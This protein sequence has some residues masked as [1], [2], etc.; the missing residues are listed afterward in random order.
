[1]YLI[2]LISSI[3]GFVLTT[4]LLFKKPPI[5]KATFFLGCFYLILSIYALQTYMIEAGHLNRF[6]WFFLWPLALYHLIMV[7]MYFYFEA[8][9]EDRFYWKKRYLLLFVP[10]LLGIMDLIAVYTT[11][12]MADQILHE[13]IA[14]TGNRLKTRYWLL[15]LNEHYLIRHIW[16]CA[17]LLVLLPK[18][19][20]FLK[21]GASNKS[22]IILNKWLV[23]FW[24]IL[25]MLSLMTILQGMEKWMDISV[26]GYFFGVG[27]G[28]IIVAII[29]YLCVLAIG[30]TPIYFPSILYGYPRPKKIPSTVNTKNKIT[31]KSPDLK[32]GLDEEGIKR[33]LEGLGQ[34]KSYLDIE[35]NVSKCARE[36]EMPEHHLSYFINQYYG[37]SFT[38]Y[39]N[40]LRMEYAKKLIQDG[41]LQNNSMEALA[42]ECGFG[43]RSSFSKAF[44]SSEELSPSEYILEI[45]RNN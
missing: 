21:E 25:L 32:F 5:T 24:L 35:F 30:V 26:F 33:K 41:F 37:L 36:L 6:P 34:R 23:F 19:R 44:K 29:L 18:L 42:T 8:I 45:R 22:K 10:F 40:K 16:Q 9:L 7:P 43:N 17:F 13:T 1:M 31:D 15:D 39:K 11:P 20:G 4:L 38:A 12:G 3:F 2:L 27:N 28:S 14:D